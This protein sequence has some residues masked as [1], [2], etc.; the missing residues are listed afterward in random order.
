MQQ[1]TNQGVGLVESAS[2]FDDF[3]QHPL[4]G[5]AYADET[6]RLDANLLLACVA[7][8]SSCVPEIYIY[9]S[10]GL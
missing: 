8:C 1:R 4:I 6:A 9:G 7:D 3:C 5:R 2:K 10:R